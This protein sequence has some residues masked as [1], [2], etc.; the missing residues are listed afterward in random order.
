M[1]FALKADSVQLND[2]TVEARVAGEVFT[3]TPS[4]NPKNFADYKQNVS[5]ALGT[6]NRYYFYFTN[7]LA[8]QMSQ[9]IEFRIYA[10]GVLI[11]DVC[12]YSVE[13]YV[14]QA[15]PIQGQIDKDLLM[16]MMKYGK[17]A[18]KFGTM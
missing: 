15:Y 2:I 9:T 16:S 11:S 6:E 14:Q 10:N 5:G 1:T 4:A 13:S 7:I 12:T 3:Y 18:E 8:N 17:A